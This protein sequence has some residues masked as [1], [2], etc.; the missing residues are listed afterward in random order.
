MT[1]GSS[2]VLNPICFGAQKCRGNE[3]QLHSHLG[4][5]FT[6]DYGINKV[7]HYVFGQR[8]VWVTDCYAVKFLLPYEG[9]NPAIL[10]LQ[11]RLMCWDMDI[12]HRPDYELVDANYWSQ[13][14]I[15]IDFNPLFLRLSQICD[16][17]KEVSCCPHQPANAPQEHALLSR[18]PCSACDQDQRVCRRPPHS[19]PYH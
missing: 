10:C 2:A 15:D 4:K 11:M 13:L 8:F 16:G 18:P 19:K 9:G 7:R 14:S 17:P 1:T 6:G 3:V 5:Y 12:V